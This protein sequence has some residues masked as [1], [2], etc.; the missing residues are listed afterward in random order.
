[1]PNPL[2]SDAFV[3]FVLFDWLEVESLCR[4][5]HFRD[6]SRATFE[7]WLA[8][9]RRVA[10]EVLWPT[11]RAMDEA[12]PRFERGRV[13]AHPSMKG[14]WRELVDLGVLSA[15]RPLGV[16]G[17]QLPLTVASLSSAYLMAANLSAYGYAGLTTGAAHL[18]EVFGSDEVRAQFLAPLSE[19]RWTGTMAL[20][21]PQAGSSLA[22][23]TSAATPLG[24]GRYRLRGSKLFISGGDH[25]VTENVVHLVLARIDGAPAGTKGI[26][27][28]AV[29][30]LRSEGGGLVDNDVAVTG[31]IHKTGRRNDAACTRR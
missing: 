12:P 26:S 31:V 2:V 17:Q 14:C 13:V 9:C 28:F 11:Y 7:P 4:L 16:G 24:E 20:T 15:T 21:E 3:D 8:A 18:I 25:D 10:R 27:L 1:M 30:R 29:P 19:G 6:H 22:D 23:L 5:P